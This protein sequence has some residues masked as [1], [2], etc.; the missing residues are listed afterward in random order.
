MERARRVVARG[1]DASARDEIGGLLR[2]LARSRTI[3]LDRLA[4]GLHGTATAQTILAS[5]DGGLTLMLVRFPHEA[6]TPV[7]DHRSWGVACVVEGVDPPD[8]IHSQ[9]GVGAAAY[10]LVCFGRN[11]MN[12]TRQYF[13]PHNGTVTERPPA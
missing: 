3:Q 4:A 5:D 9:Q 13:D 1:V 8:D 2:E 12:G 7:H 10:E 6:A 11:P